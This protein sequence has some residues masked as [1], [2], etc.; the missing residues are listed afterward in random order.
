MKNILDNNYANRYITIN[1]LECIDNN[2]IIF[3]INCLLNTPE[4]S[5]RSW[6]IEGLDQG[7]PRLILRLIYQYSNYD[8]LENFDEVKRKYLF[9]KFEMQMS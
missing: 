7:D 6:S 8:Y 1:N 4:R 9:S 5:C 2:P 3:F